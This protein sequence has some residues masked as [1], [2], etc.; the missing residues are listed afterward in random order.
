MMGDVSPL[1]NYIK[2]NFKKNVYNLN[3]KTKQKGGIGS[4]NTNGSKITCVY[5][6]K[7]NNMKIILYC[8]ATLS[9]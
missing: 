6:V 1:S 9:T 2:F 4:K 5:E 8:L 3:Y 7:N